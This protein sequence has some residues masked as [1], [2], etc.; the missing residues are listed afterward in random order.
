V[1]N[2][3]NEIYSQKTLQYIH[4]QNLIMRGVPKYLPTYPLHACQQRRP[5]S[6]HSEEG[7]FTSLVDKT[8]TARTECLVLVVKKVI[9]IMKG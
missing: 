2:F 5:I 6:F 3:N 7:F 4:L 9:G 8:Y 1:L